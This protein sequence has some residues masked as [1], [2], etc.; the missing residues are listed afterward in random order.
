MAVELRS[1]EN[2]AFLRMDVISTGEKAYPSVQVQVEAQVEGFGGREAIWLDQDA[3]TKFSE[4]LDLLERTRKGRANLTPSFPDLRL[5]IS[6]MDASGHLLVE[7]VLVRHSLV[8][9]RLRR[10]DLSLSGGFE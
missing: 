8:G 6:A 7:F 9:D 3:L 4:S 1:T 5:S 2:N 10:V